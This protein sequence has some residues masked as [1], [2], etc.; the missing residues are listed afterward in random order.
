MIETGTPIT[1]I[2][3]S[4]LTLVGAGTMLEQRRSG[5]G[6]TAMVLGIVGMLFGILDLIQ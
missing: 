6:W 3:L 4:F 2:T 1:L 5:T